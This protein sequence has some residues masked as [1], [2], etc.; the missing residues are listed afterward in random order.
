MVS[1]L[2]ASLRAVLVWP[3]PRRALVDSAAAPLPLAY[4]VLG[5]REA[6]RRA[7]MI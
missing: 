4:G 7:S 3:W 5:F 2:V 6:P 1:P